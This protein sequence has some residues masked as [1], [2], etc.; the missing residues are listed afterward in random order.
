MERSGMYGL[1]FLSMWAILEH[2]TTSI[3]PPHVQTYKKNSCHCLNSAIPNTIIHPIM[4]VSVVEISII[5]I[6]YN[7]LQSNIKSNISLSRRVL[8][9]RFSS[10]VSQLITS[11]LYRLTVYPYKQ[12][13]GIPVV[14]LHESQAQHF[15]HHRLS[16]LHQELQFHQDT[17]DLRLGYPLWKDSLKGQTGDMCYTVVLQRPLGV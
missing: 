2:G 14:Y 5:T 6:I 8:K 12:T 7:H 17:S 4:S 1:W 3:L 15:L 16:F 9:R 13:L 10:S 11:R